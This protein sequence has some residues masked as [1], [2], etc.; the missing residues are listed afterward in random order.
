VITI[1]GRTEKLELCSCVGSSGDFWL[2]FIAGLP[3]L[4]K[5]MGLGYDRYYL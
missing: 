5:M 2:V 1:T 4:T 3:P